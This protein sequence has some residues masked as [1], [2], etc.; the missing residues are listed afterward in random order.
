MEQRGREHDS[1]DELVE[2]TIDAEAKASLQPPS[3][4]RELDHRCP[5]GNRPAH[6]TVAKSQAPATNDPRDEPA[7]KAQNNPAPLAHRKW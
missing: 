1:W 5:R 2:K 4:L 3:M 7:D 6:T